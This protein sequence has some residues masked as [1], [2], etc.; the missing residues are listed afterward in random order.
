MER[1][2]VKPL[3]R[4]G[5]LWI[6]RNE[7]LSDLKNIPPGSIVKVY[8]SRENRLVGVGYINPKSVISIRLLSFKDEKID[9]DFLRKRILSSVKYREDFL[10]MKDN[11]RVIFSESDFL[12]GLIV[13]RFGNLLVIQIT[14]MGME[15]LKRRILSILDDLLSPEVIILKNDSQARLKEGLKIEIDVVK[16]KLEN[17]PTIIENNLQFLID[18]I[19]GQKTGFF[20]D[21]RDNRIFLKNLIKSG[22]GLDLFCYTGAWSITLAN[23]NTEIIGIDSS[24]RAIEIARENAKLNR[25]AERCKFLRAD[26]FEFLKWESKKDKK[27]DFIILDPPA[28]VKSREEKNDA[29]EGYLNLN[30]LAMKLLKKDGILATSS[31]SQHISETEFSEILRE[32][33]LKNKKT[34]KLIYKGT[35]SKDHP[36]LI[37]MPE[38]AYL[39]CFILKIF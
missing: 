36:I 17:L 37:T 32:A 27:Y 12:P 38:T 1:I 28:F 33:V 24:E 6:Y 34:A 23:E 4:H 11:Y 7:I 31:C 26:A 13:D 5:S 25:V 39:K 30:S 20:L 35:Q 16:G 15:Q 3:K 18:P 2:F 22:S 10:G 8:E 29:I 14:T 9:D 21:Q 19:Q